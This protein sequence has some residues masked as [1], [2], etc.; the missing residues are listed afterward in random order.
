MIHC[1]W[2]PLAPRSRTMVGS[3]TFRIVLSMV[4]MS[5]DMHTTIK[6]IQPR[7]SSRDDWDTHPSSG[8]SINRMVNS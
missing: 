5:S 3:A 7:R 2:D 4:M 6:V 1:S 8:G